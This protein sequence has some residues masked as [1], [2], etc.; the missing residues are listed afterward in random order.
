MLIG[1]G[2]FGPLRTAIV[3]IISGLYCTYMIMINDNDNDKF[4]CFGGRQEES[5]GGPL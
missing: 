5:P 3:G 1:F 4:I 2:L